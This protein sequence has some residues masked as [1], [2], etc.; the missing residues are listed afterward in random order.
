[1]QYPQ[2]DKGSSGSRGG[3][4]LLAVLV[5]F[6]NRLEV[7]GVNGWDCIP[8]LSEESSEGGIIHGCNSGTGVYSDPLEAVMPL[9]RLVAVLYLA[10]YFYF[11]GFDSATVPI[12]LVP[13]TSLSVTP[14]QRPYLMDPP[15]QYLEAEPIHG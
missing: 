13:R 2:T 14:C 1:L 9:L 12:W 3:I 11:S 4:A 8:G 6:P 7:G 15:K 10:G 5:N